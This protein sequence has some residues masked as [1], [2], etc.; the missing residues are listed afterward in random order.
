MKN[1][2][3]QEFFRESVQAGKS[4]SNRPL[5]LL[6][7]LAA[8]ALL[9]ACSRRQVDIVSR[10]TITGSVNGSPL[11]GRVSATISSSR[12]GRSTCE[13]PHLPPGFTPGTFGPQT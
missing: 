13:F 10:T 8:G 3:S 2:P 5:I 12:G 1:N 7:L 9:A 11:E 6:S 4:T